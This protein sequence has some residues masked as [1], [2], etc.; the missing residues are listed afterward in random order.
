MSPDTPD[1]DRTVVRPT[2]TPGGAGG[3]G[4]AATTHYAPTQL[5]AGAPE[6]EAGSGLPVGT[7]LFEFEITSFVGEG[8][9]G[10]VYA[11]TD[12]SLGRRVALKEY[13]PSSLSLR[14]TQ[15]QVQVRNE[16]YRETF[17]AGLKSFVN[18]ARL[19]ASFDHPSLVKV[20]RFWEANGTAYMVMPFLEGQTLRDIL[21]GMGHAPDEAWLRSVLGP[22]T[23]ALLVIH[24]EQCYHRDIAPDNVMQLPN[25]RWL[26][27]DFGAARR[28]IGDMTQAL[29]VILKPGYAPI[30]QYAEIP[31]MKQGAWTDV[32]A[33]AAVVY[34][35]ITGKTPPP[36]VG[37]MLNDT[38]QPLVQVAAGRYSPE[39][40]AAVDNAL[41]V[42]PEARFQS[43]GEF[44][45]ALG[46]EAE[47]FDPY[48]S[49]PLAPPPEG[50]R[51]RPPTQPVPLDATVLVPPAPPPTARPPV[52][53]AAASSVRPT[54]TPT[55]RAEPALPQQGG[56]KTG[57]VV[58]G[59]I[60]ALALLGIGA[61]F[62][63]APAPR[64]AP[65]PVA[66][67]PAP[68]PVAVA[69]APAPVP[70]PTPAPP[71]P[72]PPF[73]VPREFE[74][75]VQAQTAGFA[76]RAE[77]AKTE[78]RIGRDE[79]R[80]TVTSDRDGL[81]YVFGYGS[82]GTLAQLVPNRRSGVVRVRKGQ[83]WRFPAADRFTLVPDEPPGPTHLLV[84]VSAQPR[85]LDGLR[86][87]A[88]G[89]VKLYPAKAA[90][91]GLA[92]AYAGPRSVLIGS[93]AC[94]G[95][96]ACDDEYGA[97]VLRFETVK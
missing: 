74:R 47:P 28:V 43:I 39:F 71:P 77:A 94:P 48:V 75:V 54:G 97:A 29:T 51:A 17:E 93:A 26:L 30:E 59:G 46:L 12:H 41:A 80:F 60:A 92:A 15:G 36:S 68:A 72:P 25:G 52:A 42:R 5:G 89:D 19:L 63:L 14:N 64:P 22:L 1:D 70:A 84:M 13:M 65:P 24:A 95:G 32:Y 67:T 57:L 2:M 88:A 4:F 23:E 56:S 91:E 73:E 34:N 82:D 61:Y 8:G 18:E 79:F 96:G 20:Y 50:L 76:V 49:R 69:P 7:R 66:A 38:Y 86:L 6:A 85:T 90:L 16:R 78:L 81:L 87:E 37:R 58:G 44:R 62:V 83:A 27:L 45:T 53:P 11:A 33:L 9:F 21:R 3:T 40:L 31:G 10:I 55:S 35:A